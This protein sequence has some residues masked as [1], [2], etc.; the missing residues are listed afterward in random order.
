MQ[1]TQDSFKAGAQTVLDAC[2]GLK[3]EERI[4]IVVD[5]KND[6]RVKHLVSIAEELG[7]LVTV[8]QIEGQITREPPQH[9][10]A[11]MRRNEITLFCVN[12]QRTL[13][14]GHADAKVAAIK[15]GARVLFLTQD[16]YETPR[17]SELEQIR[18]RSNKLADILEQ[19]SKVKLVTGIESQLEIKLASRKSLRLSSILS[20]PGCWGAVPDYAEAAVAPLETGSNGTVRINGMIVG[21]GKV[22][23]PVDLEFEKGRLVKISGGK[24]ASDFEKLLSEYD[25][26]ARVL[27]ELGFGTNHLRREVRGEFDDKKALGSVHIALGDNHTFGGENRSDLHIDCLMANPKVYFDGSLFELKSL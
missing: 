25:N 10:A 23:T 1:S 6:H 20:R 2:A 4:L 27:C 26:S 18:I 12:E 17:A 8:E 11:E 21:I 16:I 3:K 7:A 14:W 5:S 13:L 19:T 24:V 15:N 9:I 22:D